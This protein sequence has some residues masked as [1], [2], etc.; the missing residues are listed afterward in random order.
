MFTVRRF[1]WAFALNLLALSGT[2]FPDDKKATDYGWKETRYYLSMGSSS[3]KQSEIAKIEAEMNKEL[4][5]VPGVVIDRVKFW[6]VFGT[7][8]NKD[9]RIILRYEYDGNKERKAP[10]VKMFDVLNFSSETQR[11]MDDA[12]RDK[13]CEENVRANIISVSD[14]GY[15]ARHISIYFYDPA[16]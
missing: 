14:W 7:S 16:P 15:D 9:A 3:R 12:A 11:K 6:V 13:W 10:M 1:A 5:S 4:A 8:T 2:M